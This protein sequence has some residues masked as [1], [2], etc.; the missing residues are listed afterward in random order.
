MTAGPTVCGTVV[1]VAPRLRLVEVPRGHTVK[2]QDFVSTLR[3]YDYVEPPT[4]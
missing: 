1:K 2:S 4:I 3:P